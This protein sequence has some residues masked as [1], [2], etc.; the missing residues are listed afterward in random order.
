MRASKKKSTKWATKKPWYVMC[1]VAFSALGRGGFGCRAQTT[2]SA[3]DFLR[4]LLS[5][6]SSTQGNGAEV[7]DLIRSFGS[8]QNVESWDALKSAYDVLSAA[9]PSS[10]TAET[11]TES[12][13][14]DGEFLKSLLGTLGDG[15][16]GATS[17]SAGTIFSGR[18]DFFTR[19]LQD[20]IQASGDGATF[21][22]GTFANNLLENL[23]AVEPADMI[24]TVMEAIQQNTNNN[25]DTASTTG[26]EENIVQSLSGIQPSSLPLSDEIRN[27]ISR[28]LTAAAEKFNLTLSGNFTREDARLLGEKIIQE[29][30]TS[31]N[32]ANVFETNFSP[33]LREVFISFF[34]ASLAQRATA[35]NT[36][37]VRFDDGGRNTPGTT[38]AQKEFE[39]IKNVIWI[40]VDS[41]A[42]FASDIFALDRDNVD[43]EDVIALYDRVI[44]IMSNSRQVFAEVLAD[45]A[46]NATGV[47]SDTLRRAQALLEAFRTS[48]F[49]QYQDQD[50][51]EVRE[52]SSANTV[53]SVK[54]RVIDAPSAQTETVSNKRPTLTKRTK[55]IIIAFCT[56]FTIVLIFLCAF[57]KWSQS[58]F[59]SVSSSSDVLDEDGNETLRDATLIERRIS[60]AESIDNQPRSRPPSP[61][62]LPRK[63]SLVQRTPERTPSAGY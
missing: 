10:G 57:N 59:G 40:S 49:Y 15:G 20:V 45:A 43:T 52:M 19:M 32:D 44:G 11:T 13:F 34:T 54:D 26:G 33:Q 7:F 47:E 29:A 62:F 21:G 5:K 42:R 2:A 16:S 9:Q 23:N 18:D 41:A 61:D 27:D 31:A 30:I 17:A 51:E 63:S 53:G 28:R 6:N 12:M 24:R 37:D 56:T 38:D 58:R 25:D 1:F 22:D 55:Q 60:K 14:G 48:G 50:Q 8:G 36:T 4:D 35:N 46:K 3:F 39:A